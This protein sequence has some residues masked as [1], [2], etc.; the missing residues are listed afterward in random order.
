MSGKSTVMCEIKMVKSIG[1]ITLI[2]PPRLV[3]DSFTTI[4]SM[5]QSSQALSLLV[6][7]VMRS[8]LCLMYLSPLTRG[9]NL[10]K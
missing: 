9:A 3:R 2:N 6:F 8:S 5:N 1:V 7:N 10:S 4:L